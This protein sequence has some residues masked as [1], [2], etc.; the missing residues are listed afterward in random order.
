[1]VARRKKFLA[2]TFGAAM[3]TM[4]AAPELQAD[5]VDLTFTPNSINEGSV[6]TLTVSPLSTFILAVN[7]TMSTTFYGFKAAIGGN[8]A[9]ELG[10]VDYSQTLTVNASLPYSFGP[11]TVLFRPLSTAPLQGGGSQFVGFR[12]NGNVGWFSVD[13]SDP[14]VLRIVDGE[15]GSNG[16]A[17]HVGGTVPEP[18][19]AT[20]LAALALGAIGVRRNRK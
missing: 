16:E 10:M 11:N 14:A 7:L 12:F 8:S 15:Y 4:Y 9:F 5:I 6:G 18:T 19:G 20:A 13:F 3:A 2:T 1:M 17:V